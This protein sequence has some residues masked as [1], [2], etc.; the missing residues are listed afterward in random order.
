M[1]AL[2]FMRFLAKPFQIAYILPSS[3]AVV[4]RVSAK[5]DFSEPSIIVELGPGEGC[6]TREIVQKMHPESRLLLFELD[7]KLTEHLRAQFADDP[8]VEVLNTDALRIK[9]ELRARGIDYCDYVVSGVPF[10]CVPVKKK[11]RIVRA[12]Y[13]SLA[14][15]HKSAFLVYQV[16]TELRQH[17]KMFAR[18][19]SH[20][21]VPN[22]PP[23][24]VTAYYKQAL[25]NGKHYP[26][27]KNGPTV[28]HIRHANG[29]GKQMVEESSRR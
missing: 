24:I 15:N 18:S 8:R 25:P 21:F 19:E 7:V 11:R 20:Y 6:H 3:R 4:R 17:T 16:T 2:L 23:M 22:I 26:N 27:G 9:D 29:K 28:H 5:M 1:S 14:P 13:D 10:S 12:V